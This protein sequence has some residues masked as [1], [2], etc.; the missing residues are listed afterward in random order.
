MGKNEY[1]CFVDEANV[2]RVPAPIEA[3]IVPSVALDAGSS[4]GPSQPAQ[5]AM[6]GVGK[7]LSALL[8]CGVLLLV[9]YGIYRFLLPFWAPILFYTYVL[10]AL[11]VLGLAVREL[12]RDQKR[13]SE[14]QP[15]SEKVGKAARK[16]TIPA[17]L[18]RARDRIAMV[19]R[20]LANAI[21]WP[22]TFL[23]SRQVV[24][25]HGRPGMTLEEFAL[26]AVDRPE[27]NFALFSL[28]ITAVVTAG[29]LLGIIPGLYGKAALAL[30]IAGTTLRH[31]QYS[32][33]TVPLPTSL[34]RVTNRPYTA[35]IAIL[36]CD[37]ATLILALTCL[38]SARIPPAHIHL[39]DFWNT[40]KQ[41]AEP[42]D[43]PMA[44][45]KSRHLDMHEVILGLVALFLDLALLEIWRHRREFIRKDEDHVWLASTANR[46]GDFA[47]AMRHLR[48]VKHLDADS[49][50][51]E[52]SALLGV[53]ELERAESELKSALE[54]T[55]RLA[56]PD[57][58]FT[59]LWGLGAMLPLSNDVHIGLLKSA[60]RSKVK[61][62]YLL[63]AIGLHEASEDFKQRALGVFFPVK[64]QYP[65][66]SAALLSW[67]DP[68][69]AASLLQRT[70]FEF[71]VDEASAMVIRLAIVL[72]DANTSSDQDRK[73]LDDWCDQDLSKFRALCAALTDSYDILAVASSFRSIVQR[74]RNL[75][76]GR[77]EQLAFV[78]DSLIVRIKD[79]DA[80]A[81]VVQMDA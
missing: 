34:R 29:L 43:A 5:K 45:L 16:N 6:S 35:F 7:L 33:G 9:G 1:A 36:V 79:P 47:L 56:S 25:H 24:R 23:H 14:E 17:R 65:L 50:I 8:I 77:A 41:L 20:T 40:T 32:I 27:Q 64:D 37:F 19:A 18:E 4:V 30:L 26:R 78:Y 72:G 70:D 53:N 80:K 73:A 44:L 67:S 76:S 62:T 48:N 39:L 60:I 61:D 28:M 21:A 11:L 74:A 2:N 68:E 66:T 52:V 46:L 22:V 81:F 31:I 49:R 38:S 10:V 15:F 54:E 59:T 42:W 12:K 13:R 58:I 75:G 69:V 3:E 55:E 63:S 51:V 57:R 71:T